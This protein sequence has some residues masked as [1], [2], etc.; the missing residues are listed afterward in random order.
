MSSMNS[1]SGQRLALAGLTV[2]SSLWSEAVAA[3]HLFAH[4]HGVIS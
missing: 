3:G 2:M 1:C 4:I